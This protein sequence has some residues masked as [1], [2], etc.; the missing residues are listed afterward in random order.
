M[1]S[2]AYRLWIAAPEIVVPVLCP[3]G[4][5]AC[6]FHEHWIAPLHHIDYL[7]GSRIHGHVNDVVKLL[8]IGAAKLYLCGVLE[9]DFTRKRNIKEGVELLDSYRENFYVLEFLPF[10]HFDLDGGGFLRIGSSLS[11]FWKDYKYQE[12]WGDQ[13]VY[14]PGWAHFGWERSWE[15][16]SFGNEFSFINFSEADLEIPAYEKWNLILS[17]DLWSHQV[18]RRTKRYYG[19]NISQEGVYSF[20][21]SAERK[22][23]LKESWFGGTFGLFIGRRLSLGLFLDLP[24]YYDKWFSTEINGQ[25]GD[26]FKGLTDSQP[27]I[28]TPVGFWT[29]IIWRW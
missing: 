13:K 1:T 14:S 26:Y 27:M 8:N 9:A 20:H 18:Y 28:R 6:L 7:P 2:Y 5:V 3:V 10:I 15:R 22:N 4:F 17:V 11:F 29:M 19:N 21:K 25:E 12:V 24:V 23:V 16:S